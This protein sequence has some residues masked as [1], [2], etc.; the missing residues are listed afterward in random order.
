M[1]K[2]ILLILSMVISATCL[3]QEESDKSKSKTIEFMSQGSSLIKKEFYDLGKV[4]G[5]GCQVLI[6]TNLLNDAKLGCL[7]LETKYQGYSSSETY[8]GTLDYD[9]IDDCLNS[10]NYICENILPSVPS[11]YTET[12]YSTRDNIE[13]GAYYSESK[14]SWTAY[15]YTKNYTSRSVEFFDSESLSSLAEIMQRAKMMI[16]EKVQ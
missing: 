6:V 9:E 8:V 2:Y 5:I 4:K 14:S 15:V 16:S 3:A 10:I 1:K 11:V 13:V 12:E 7:R